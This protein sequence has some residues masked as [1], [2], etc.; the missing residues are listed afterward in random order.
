MGTIERE[1]EE[2]IGEA[3]QLKEALDVKEQVEQKYKHLK[4]KYED[5]KQSNK[6][7]MESLTENWEAE[8]S[9]KEKQLEKLKFNLSLSPSKDSIESL[10]ADKKKLEDKVS[11]LEKS[12]KEGGNEVESPSS[13]DPDLQADHEF[14]TGQVDF[15]NSVIVDLH[16]K[17]DEL[18]MRLE[19]FENDVTGMSNGVADGSG[20]ASLNAS[21]AAAPRLFCDICD[22][23][24]LHDTEDCPT[25]TMIGGDDDDDDNDETLHAHHH[26]SRSAS[27]PYCLNCE[28]FGHDTED[29][30]GEETF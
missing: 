1:K 21:R 4:H 24:D 19:V 27:R 30:D 23:F 14:L 10:K 7:E 3:A 13:A 29:C 11:R 18:Q 17:N 20:D 2:A 6:A 22:E 25:Q 28:A 12:L 9:A 5:M 16:R 8:L 26:G 15:L